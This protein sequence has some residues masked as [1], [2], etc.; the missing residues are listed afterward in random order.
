VAR[1]GRVAGLVSAGCKV[2]RET[3]V[4]RASGALKAT[5]GYRASAAHRVSAAL[6]GRLDRRSQRESEAPMR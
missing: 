6:S 1:V 3:L 5:A 2:R 4:L